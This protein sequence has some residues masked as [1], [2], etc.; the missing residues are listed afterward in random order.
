MD[1]GVIFYARSGQ[2]SRS[3]YQFEHRLFLCKENI[4]IISLLFLNTALML[5]KQF[6]F[7]VTECWYL[8]VPMLLSWMPRQFYPIFP[9]QSP[10][11]PSFPYIFFAFYLHTPSYLYVCA[12]FYLYTPSYSHLSPLFYLC[13]P[14]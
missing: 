9:L 12:P 8:N 7:Y 6:F 1:F 3:I 13:P 2:L 10:C 5:V 14:W 11:T 4:K